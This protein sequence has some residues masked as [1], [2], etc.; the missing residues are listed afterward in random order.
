MSMYS[1]QYNNLCY[2]V[3]IYFLDVSRTFLRA[4]MQSSGL[5]GRW[6]ASIILTTS[7]S[8]EHYTFVSNIQQPNLSDRDLN[9]FTDTD[10]RQSAQSIVS[11]NP[12]F[13]STRNTP[14]RNSLLLAPKA[15]KSFQH[16]NDS[17]YF[18]LIRACSIIVQK[19]HAFKIN[20]PPP[21]VIF[22]DC[23]KALTLG[24][25]FQTWSEITPDLHVSN[26]IRR[27]SVSRPASVSGNCN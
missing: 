21:L 18:L 4:T 16:P 10:T 13:S 22:I 15:S 17:V 5:I 6:L 3:I 23:L 25:G 2:F 1:K 11:T 12:S 27:T 8:P 7:T 24:S 14:I 9:S 20:M 19:I 26:E